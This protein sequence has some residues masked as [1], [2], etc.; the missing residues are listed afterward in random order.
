VSTAGFPD[1]TVREDSAW[2]M[3]QCE[4]ALTWAK[5]KEVFS[6]AENRD[7]QPRSLVCYELGLLGQLPRTR[8][9]FNAADPTWESS[10]GHGHELDAD[11]R[12]TYF[13]LAFR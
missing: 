11:A 3:G 13:Y 6:R 10:E 2:T 8:S 5:F 9:P 12:L 1:S 4:G 7:Q